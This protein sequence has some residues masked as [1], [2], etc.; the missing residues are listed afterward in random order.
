MKKPN[1]LGLYDMGRNVLECYSGW[2]H[3]D[4]YSNSPQTHSKGPFSGT[5]KILRGCNWP[6]DPVRTSV[7]F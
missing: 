5:W 7:Y 4:Y 6:Y 2:Y 1:E 3:E